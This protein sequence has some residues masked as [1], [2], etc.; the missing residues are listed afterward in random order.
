M[1]GSVARRRRRRRRRADPERNRQ[2]GNG[3][4]IEQKQTK[5]QRHFHFLNTNTNTQNQT[6]NASKASIP[7]PYR[8]KKN[9]KPTGYRLRSTIGFAKPLRVGMRPSRKTFGSFDRPTIV[10]SRLETIKPTDATLRRAPFEILIRKRIKVKKCRR[11]ENQD[12]FASSVDSSKVGE[13]DLEKWRK[14]LPS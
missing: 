8:L 7:K 1:D 13:L 5:K 3:A 10:K 2:K 4:E 14:K 12:A 9:Q 6:A 11:A